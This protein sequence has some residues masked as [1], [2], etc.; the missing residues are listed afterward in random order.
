LNTKLSIIIPTY[1]EEKLLGTLLNKFPK[2][3]KD[4][5]NLELIVSDGGS[6][7][8]TLDIANQ[9]ADKVVQ[10]SATQK[11]SIAQGRN[12]GADASSSDVLI[13][14]NADC[15]PENIEFFLEFITK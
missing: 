6:T 1:L 15:M 10:S 7:D 2:D 14:L 13:F 4:K 5:Y 11:R 12:N 8:S 3:I 9:F